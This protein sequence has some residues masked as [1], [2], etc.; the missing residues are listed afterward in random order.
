MSILQICDTLLDKILESKVYDRETLYLLTMHQFL[1]RVFPRIISEY[2][3]NIE[4]Y[5]CDS[6]VKNH[7]FPSKISTLF[8]SI[9]AK[10]D[11]KVC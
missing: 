5:Y 7:G 10:C 1:Y 11:S 8:K 2:P 3:N 9:M 4:I 6:C